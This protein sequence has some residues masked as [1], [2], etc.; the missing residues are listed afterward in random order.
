MYS[1]FRN[2]TIKKGL[3]SEAWLREQ[4]IPIEE[5]PLV[6]VNANGASVGKVFFR[7]ERCVLTDDVIAVSVKNDNIDPEFLAVQL[8][9]AVAA[10]GFLYEAKLFVG[11]VKE[12]SVQIPVTPTGE[13]DIEQQPQIAAAVKRFDSIR[14]RLHELGNWSSEA[15]VS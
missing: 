3:I 1:C 14:T 11:R 10:G 13:Y 4:K 6:T 12:L 5:R 15:R 8:R 9:S 2:S 7:N